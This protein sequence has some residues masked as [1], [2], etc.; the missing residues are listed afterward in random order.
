MKKV[1]LNTGGQ[2]LL[3]NWVPGFRVFAVDPF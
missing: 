1:V 3:G 2:L